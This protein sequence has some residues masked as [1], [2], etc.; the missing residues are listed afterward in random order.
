MNQVYLPPDANCFLSTIHHCLGSKNYTNLVIGSKQPTAVYL[1]PSEA[2]EHC[3]QGAG[4]WHFASSQDSTSDGPKSSTA[5]PDVVLVGIG[6]EV[7]FEV[8]K[9]A[10]LVRALCPSLRVRVI[11]VTDLMILAPESRH[12]HA[13]SRARFQ[14]LFTADKPVLFNYHGYTTELQGLLFGRPGVERM[15]VEGYREEGTTTTPF[16]MMILN[17]VSRFDVAARAVKAGAKSNERVKERLGDIQ[18]EVDKRLRDVRDYIVKFGKGKQPSPFHA[19]SATPERDVANMAA[20]SGRHLQ[21]SAVFLMAEGI[22][23]A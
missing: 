8:V 17:H 21:L 23:R 20:R 9:A 5:D 14:E 1:T 18:A 15:S 16:D 12:P 10:E 19:D 13:L 2:A 11:N 3:R 22:A 7:T 6:V 4:I